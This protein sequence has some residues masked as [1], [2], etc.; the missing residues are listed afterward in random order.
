VTGLF[1]GVFTLS[2]SASAWKFHH[3]WLT[4]S[5]HQKFLIYAACAMIFFYF[6]VSSFARARR[7]S[8]SKA[9]SR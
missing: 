5:N 7:K 6:T 1:F 4:G 9:G 3:S 8:R 2:F